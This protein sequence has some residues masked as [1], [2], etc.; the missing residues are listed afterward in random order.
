MVQVT[1]MGQGGCGRPREMLEHSKY[2]QGDEIDWIQLWIIFQGCGKGGVWMTLR[3]LTFVIKQ[4]WFIHQVMEQ[5][6]NK[7]FEAEE[8]HHKQSTGR[9]LKT[10]PGQSMNA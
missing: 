4:W 2:V 6:K 7:E 5:Y 9:T 10:V 1:E 8:G 3:F